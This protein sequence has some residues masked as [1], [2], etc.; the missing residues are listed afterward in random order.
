MENKSRPLQPQNKV[1][2]K[3]RDDEL[4]VWKQNDIDI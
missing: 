3:V 1:T 4:H 2:F